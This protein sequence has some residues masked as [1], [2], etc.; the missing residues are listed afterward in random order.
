M[1]RL[2]VRRP[3]IR[4]GTLSLSCSNRIVKLTCVPIGTVQQTVGG[5]QEEDGQVQA[6]Q[7][8]HGDLC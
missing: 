4:Q 7:H 8:H 3:E 6:H 5:Y 2:T 1:M